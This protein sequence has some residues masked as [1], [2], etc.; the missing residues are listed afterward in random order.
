M[1]VVGPEAASGAP[2]ADHGPADPVNPF[3]VC[4]VGDGFE[5]P[6]L[7]GRPVT[8]DDA[9]RLARIFRALADPARVRLLSLLAARP[10][11]E[12]CVN[13]L[14]AQVE[15]AQPTVSH[16]LKVLFEVGL[17]ERERRGSW[18]YYRLHRGSLREISRM[19]G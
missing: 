6:D 11:Q 5:C 3:I 4:G 15:L 13:D 17:V 1:C 14:L 7:L 2:L 19:L 12:S 18:V 16:H 10:E 8:D 9:E